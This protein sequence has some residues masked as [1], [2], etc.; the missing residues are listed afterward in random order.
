MTQL[1]WQKKRKAFLSSHHLAIIL[2]GKLR[3]S[4]FQGLLCRSWHSV[5][6]GKNGLYVMQHSRSPFWQNSCLSHFLNMEK[7]KSPSIQRDPKKLSLNANSNEYMYKVRRM[8]LVPLDLKVNFAFEKK[9]ALF[10]ECAIIWRGRWCSLPYVD[11][12]RTSERK[13]SILQKYMMQK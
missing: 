5:Q 1:G 13:A 4:Q 12:W 8:R 10:T 7:K 3:P 2:L 9:V 11:N 6:P